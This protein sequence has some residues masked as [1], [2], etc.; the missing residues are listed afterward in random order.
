MVS[1]LA[2]RFGL[3]SL[4][5]ALHVVPLFVPLLMPF[6]KILSTPKRAARVITKIVTDASSQT[7]VYYNA[8]GHLRQG[9]EEW[10][11]SSR[12]GTCRLGL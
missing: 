6:I 7:G 9:E 10:D 11:R 2:N 5:S 12:T 3:W 1:E 4:L 8:G